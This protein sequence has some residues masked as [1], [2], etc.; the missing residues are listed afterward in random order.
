[1]GDQL[2][3]KPPQRKRPPP[4]REVNE[5]SDRYEVRCPDSISSL[6]LPRFKSADHR[7]CPIL[8]HLITDGTLAAEAERL[9]RRK[10]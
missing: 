9:A 10:C 1:M 6:D 2:T 8:P 7:Q 3:A 5:T 4:E